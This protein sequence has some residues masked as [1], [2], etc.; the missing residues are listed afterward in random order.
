MAHEKIKMKIGIHSPPLRIATYVGVIAIAMA[1]DQWIWLAGMLA[2]GLFWMWVDGVSMKSLGVKILSSIPLLI[3]L[4]I[5]FPLAH[6]DT[7]WAQAATYAGRFL[8]AL[9]MLTLLMHQITYAEFVQGLLKL[10]IPSIFVEML[11]FTLRYMGLFRGQAW[12]MWISMKSRGFRAGRLFSWRAWL[13]LSKLL[14]SLWVRVFQ[15]SER[16]YI[17]MISRGYD[18]QPI[19][20]ALP[21]THPHDRWKIIGFAL[22]SIGTFVMSKF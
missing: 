14:A 18:G 19:L 17:A 2:I 15:R 3:F 20:N 12:K 4:F 9:Q 21:R 1:I 16:I 22:W 7:G 10:K 11:T 13:V 5:Y 6:V 8:F